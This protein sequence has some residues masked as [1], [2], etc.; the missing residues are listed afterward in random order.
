MFIQNYTNVVEANSNKPNDYFPSLIGNFWVY[1][2][3]G[4]INI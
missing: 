1:I 2:Q 4:Y 3:V